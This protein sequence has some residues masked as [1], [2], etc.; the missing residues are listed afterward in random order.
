MVNEIE[1]SIEEGI[2]SF[3]VRDVADVLQFEELAAGDLFGRTS[4]G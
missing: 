2:R 3:Q 4:P 1:Q